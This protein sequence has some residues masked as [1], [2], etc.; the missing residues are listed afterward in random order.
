MMNLYATKVLS[1]AG[2]QSMYVPVPRRGIVKNITVA[3]NATM[4]ATGTLTASRGGTAVNL[5]TAPTGDTAAGTTLKGVLD[6]TN[7]DLVF[8]P[9]SST[10]A[11]KVIKITDDATLL[12]G[13]GTI[14]VH[15]EYDDSAAVQQLAS[16]A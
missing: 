12:G 5:A 8:D 9:D 7:K 11:N 15:I 16:E 10:V 13:A 1:G 6:T 2:S 4:V 3:C 14:A